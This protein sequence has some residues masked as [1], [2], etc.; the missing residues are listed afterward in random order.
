MPSSLVSYL[1]GQTFCS[2]STPDVGRRPARRH[3]PRRPA[4]PLGQSARVLPRAAGRRRDTTPRALQGDQAGRSPSRRDHGAA[5]ARTITHHQAYAR[6]SH[7]RLCTHHT[8][9]M[10]MPWHAQVALHRD[11]RQGDTLAVRVGRREL[12]AA[13]P[14]CDCSPVYAP[15]RL[16]SCLSGALARE[17][18]GRP[19][20]ST[21]PTRA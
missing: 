3:R 12:C 2:E 16:H 10:H 4:R 21:P 5:Y 18:T 13:Q 7:A 8:H 6:T 14:D 20:S 9:A 15:W 19:L 17:S 1:L 11:L